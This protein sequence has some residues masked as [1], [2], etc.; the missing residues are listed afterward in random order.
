MTSTPTQ[1]QLCKNEDALAYQH[2][3]VINGKFP[4]L[5]SLKGS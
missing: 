1:F 2:K 5:S 4:S 3:L